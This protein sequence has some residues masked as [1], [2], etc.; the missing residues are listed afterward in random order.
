MSS[1]AA[2]AG[3]SG[4]GSGWQ[5][6][7][8]SGLRYRLTNDPISGTETIEIENTRAYEDGGAGPSASVI[9]GHGLGDSARGWAEPVM[10]LCDLLPWT[11]WILPSAPQQ[12][13][14]VRSHARPLVLCAICTQY[15]VMAMC[16]CCMLYDTPADMW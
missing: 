10:Q 3:S 5:D 7:G 9:F 8:G 6:A 16:E 1:S 2:A 12:P 14:T 11:R 4:G 15:P 13:V